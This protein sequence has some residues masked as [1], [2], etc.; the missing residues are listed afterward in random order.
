MKL[1]A[2]SMV[3]NEA[4]V[5]EAFVRHH[6]EVVDELIVVDHCSIDGT[7]ELLHALAGEGLPLS[8][9]RETSLVHRQNLV[10]TG[11]MHEAATSGRAD[12]VVPLDADEFLV[13]PAGDVRAVL[14][15]LPRDRA[16]R[17][18]LRLYVPSPDDP[19]DESNVLRRIRHRSLERG[20]RT[21]GS[22]IWMSKVVVPAVLARD[23]RYA[24]APGDHGLVNLRR[25]EFTD[26]P[27]TDRLVL[28]HFPVRSAS[29]LARKV[30]GGFPAHVARPERR[31]DEAFHWKRL[32]D[33]ASTGRLT[34][35]TLHDF[36]VEYPARESN[37]A[38]KPELLL[39]PVPSRFELRYDVPREPSPE[40]VLADTAVRLADELSGALR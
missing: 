34:P 3:R 11:L 39:D 12:W 4:D 29:Q 13:A 9:R 25:D 21:D 24:L 16:S 6:A 15:E 38:W 7:P 27:L 35:G 31:P 23:G 14:Q 19:A 36:A 37:R 8:I 5:I 28:A 26:A 22:I 1:T 40:E 10:L 18:E 17:V 20:S 32:F 2:I 33:A 30:L